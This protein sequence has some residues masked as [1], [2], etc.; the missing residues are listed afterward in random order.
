V[1]QTG[2]FAS[3]RSSEIDF[4][5]GMTTFGFLFRESL[6]G[7]L[8]AIA[9]AGYRDVEIAPV[10]PHVP[11]NYF[12]AH[13][14]RNLTRELSVLGLKCVALNP[15]ELNLVSPNDDI[16]RLA[17]DHYISAVRLADDI[18]AETVVVVPGRQNAL[19]PR[20]HEEAVHCLVEQLSTILNDTEG[21]NVSLALE[22]APFGFLHTAASVMR[23]V[24]QFDNPRIGITVDCANILGQ[25][26]V[27]DAVRV[28][29]DRL[30][31]GHFSDTWHDR[32][33]HTSVGRGEVDFDAFRS[34][35]SAIGYNGHCIYELVDGEDPGPRIGPDRE[36]LLRAG[37][38]F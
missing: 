4:R 21:S 27:E 31:M 3:T 36:K 8:A 10:P 20:P 7:A 1:Q 16:R 14:R 29:G 30:K 5:V 6:E 13:Q 23:V 17:L 18:G 22:T 24:E 37:W 19:I 28:A 25:E 33:S 35:L 12:R 9:Q 15:P 26:D 34:S 2:R 11:S 32:F 38:K